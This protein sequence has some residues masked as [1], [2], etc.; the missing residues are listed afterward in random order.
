MKIKIVKAGRYNDA[1]RTAQECEE[2][3]VFETSVAYAEL[4]IADGLAEYVDAGPEEEVAPKKK[5]GK[6]QKTAPAAK[7][8]RNP[9][10]T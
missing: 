7:T 6:A 8:K 1:D 10:L 3:Q 5:T 4:L 2:G 9:F